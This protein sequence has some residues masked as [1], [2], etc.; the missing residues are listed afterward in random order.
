[1]CAVE[2]HATDP[3]ITSK[4]IPLGPW[5]GFGASKVPQRDQVYGFRGLILDA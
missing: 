1:M 5:T 3:R 4:K 2:I